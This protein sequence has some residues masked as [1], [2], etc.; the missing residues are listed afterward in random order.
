MILGAVGCALAPPANRGFTLRAGDEPADGARASVYRTGA[1]YGA[2]DPRTALAVDEQSGG[3][4]AF[5][6]N[7]LAVQSAA[8]LA[9]GEPIDAKQLLGILNTRGVAGLHDVQGQFAIAWWNARA[10]ELT[11]VRDHFGAEPLCYSLNNGQLVFG[12]LGRDVAAA[13]AQPPRLSMQGL[14]EYLTHC[15]LPGNSTLFENVLRVPA[16]AALVFNARTGS[17]RI[18]SWYRLSFADPVP[19]SEADI[20]ARYRELL[21]AAVVRRLDKGRTGVLLSGGMDSS[22]A[23][24]FAR[25]HLADKISSF[26]FRCV[27]ASFDESPYARQ[28]SAQL[29]TEHNEVA[30]GELESLQAVAAVG[31]MDMPFCDIG[32]EIGTWLLSQAAGSKVDYLLTGDGGDEIWASHPVYAAQRIIRW[33]D[34]MP[35]PRPLRSAL[36]R[37]C[38]IVKDSDQKRNLAVVLKR[39]LPE[40]SYPDELQHYRWRMYYTADSMRQMLTPELARAVNATE[41]FR[42]VAESFEHYHGPDDGLSA[43]LYSDY[44]TVS[45]F[46][47]SRLFLSRSCGLE[48]RMPFYD[49]DLVEFGA[50]IPVH[51]KLEGVERTKRLFRVAMEGIL[52]DIINH[53]K[54]KLGHSVPF[55]NWLRESGP[56][57]TLVRETLTSD[58]FI[59][60]GLFQRAS[61]DTMLEEHRQ[62]RH[63]HSHR[64]WALFILEQWFRK[65]FKSASA[66]SLALPADRAA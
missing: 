14:V 13:L 52:P 53:R 49:R 23:A 62:R 59:G 47:F 6:G 27:G 60:R 4:L 26:S 38:S 61:I 44:R 37:A 42:A 11:L 9:R 15:Y 7:P 55:K 64:I 66:R 51:L 33:Y 17:C 46:Y 3:W 31:E 18:E 1:R 40:P 50:R 30:Y 5:A 10:G 19:P 63:N 28:L 21:E 58:E 16:G 43:C 41:P 45:G 2:L 36:V 12:S 54:D 56:L 48:V 24:T 34:R 25:R 57:S 32:I 20:V 39:M 22:S 8:V 29:G 35:I 65:H